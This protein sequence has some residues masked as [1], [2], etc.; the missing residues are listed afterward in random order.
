MTDRIRE[1]DPDRGWRGDPDLDGPFE[2]I[3]CDH[4]PSGECLAVV[5]GVD[6]H[7]TPYTAASVHRAVTPGWE[8]ALVDKLRDGDWRQGARAIVDRTVAEWEARE[9]AREADRRERTGEL[10]DRLAGA[11]YDEWKPGSIVYNFGGG[12]K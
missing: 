12:S 8:D 9:R 5:R 11:L 3:P 4:S 7:G 1:G 10:A 2:G 6:A